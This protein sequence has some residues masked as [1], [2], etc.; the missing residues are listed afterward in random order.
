MKRDEFD[1]YREE[2]PSK[3]TEWHSR[4]FADHPTQVHF[5]EYAA[6][7]FFDS[8]KPGRVVEI[9]GWRGELAD[10]I[11]PKESIESWDN[12]EVCAEAARSPVCS[13]PKYRS[14]AERVLL[15]PPCATLVMSHVIEHLTDE[16]ARGVI[17]ATNASSLYVD[18]PLTEEGEDWGGSIGFH[19]LKMGW[20]D[21]DSLI[22]S[23][24]FG[25]VGRDKNARWY[26]RC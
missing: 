4:L 20:N 14:H 19:I 21:L 9:G 8:H 13:D 16:E 10:V 15:P 7:R 17:A 26:R 23:A 22:N 24:G 2:Y 6:N 25:L 3:V 18:A 11:L 5:N 1:Q 12:Y